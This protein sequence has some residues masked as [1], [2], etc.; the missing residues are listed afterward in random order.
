MM[1][2]FLS[3]EERYDKLSLYKR[4]MEVKKCTIILRIHT[5]QTILS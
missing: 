3:V 4:E 5:K 1:T 2:F